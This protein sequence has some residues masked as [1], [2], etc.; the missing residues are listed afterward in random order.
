MLGSIAM[1]H[2]PA[3]ASSVFVLAAGAVVAFSATAQADNFRYISTSGSNANACTRAA[4]CRTLHRGAAATPPGGEL[5][6]LDSGYFGASA[7]IRRAITIAGGGNTV[8]LGAPLVIDRAGAAVTLRDLVLTGEGTV[9][10]GIDITAPATVLIERCAIHGFVSSGIRIAVAGPA[11]FVHDTSIHDNGGDGIALTGG[12]GSGRLT[13]DKVRIQRNGGFGVYLEDIE[14]TIS[15]SVVSENAIS[16]IALP[17]GRVNIT[18][19]IAANNGTDGVFVAGT[20]T[21][22][23]VVARGNG[24]AGLMVPN[25]GVARI[26]NSTFTDNEIGINNFGMVQTRETNTVHGN[27]SANV[28]GTQVPTQLNGV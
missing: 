19:T 23:S 6:I 10:R 18:A 3:R 7:R 26:S 13:L 28:A 16:G 1:L 22:E 27:E 24:G 17:L 11:V 14:T 21:L 12:D 5:R 2:P 8:L 25:S 9:V 4:P 20:A 15:R